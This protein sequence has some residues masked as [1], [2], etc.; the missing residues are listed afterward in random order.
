[1]E[2][3]TRIPGVTFYLKTA[4]YKVINKRAQSTVV[5]HAEIHDPSMWED[6]RAKLKEIRIYQGDNFKNELIE[7]LQEDKAELEGEKG[8]FEEVLRTADERMKQE[9]SL[10]TRDKN[11]AENEARNLRTQLAEQQGE[12]R[13]L[14]QLERS[15]RQFAGA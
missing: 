7:I 10:A 13:R 11:I 8:T 6:I 4:D 1:M 3:D 5:L 2:P 14:Q 9:I 12:L 15:L